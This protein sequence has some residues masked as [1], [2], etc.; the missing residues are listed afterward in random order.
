VH[1]WH[2]EDADDFRIEAGHGGARRAGAGVEAGLDRAVETRTAALGSGR[3]LGHHGHAGG[4]HHGDGGEGAAAELAEDIGD[5]SGDELDQPC[6]QVVQRQALAAIRNM[7]SVTPVVGARSAPARW[8]GEA[9]PDE[10]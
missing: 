9:L 3:D 5:R 4:V 7:V 2:G 1:H 10:P 6:R 8:A